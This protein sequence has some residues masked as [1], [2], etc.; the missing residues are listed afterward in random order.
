ML[1][2]TVIT[3]ALY[4]YLFSVSLREPDVL[5]RLREET[6][7]MP[8]AEMLIPPEQGQFLNLLVQLIGAR[9][10]LELGVF[11]GYSALWTALGLGRDGLLIG[12]DLNKQWAAIARRYWQ[13]AGVDSRIELRLGPA[14]ETLNCLLQ[15]SQA[16]TFDFAFIDADKANYNQY[17]ELVLELVRP[18]GLIVLDNMLRSGE[19]LDPNST[20]AGTVAVKALNEKLG[21]DRRVVLSMLPIADGVSLAMKVTAA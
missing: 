19:V 16:E 18:G 14:V 2:R 8:E 1:D 11:T 3:P 4:D 15:E 20:E 12:C 6:S 10:T 7:K 9:R 17:Y 21:Q 13:E 5:R